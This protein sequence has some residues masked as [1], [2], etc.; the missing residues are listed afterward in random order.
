LRHFTIPANETESTRLLWKDVDEGWIRY[1]PRSGSTHLLT[2]LARHLVDV[3]GS[4]VTP[5]S[6]NDLVEGV[7]CLEP[8]AEP[9]QCAVEVEA[10]LDILSE[11]QLIQIIEP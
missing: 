6:S 8:D 2:P 7:L 9:G 5:V 3:I 10:T 11:A 1:D 4:S